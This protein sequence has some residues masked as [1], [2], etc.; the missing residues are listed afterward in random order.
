MTK[1]FVILKGIARSIQTESS[2]DISLALNMTIRLS[3]QA[4]KVSAAIYFFFCGLLRF[5]TLKQNP[6]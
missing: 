6:A 2:R 3:L 5:Y 1:N 4:N